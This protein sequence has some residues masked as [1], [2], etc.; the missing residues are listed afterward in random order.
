M[1][2]SLFGAL[3][4]VLSTSLFS[5]SNKVNHLK[6][7]VLYMP[8][9]TLTNAI[10]I[11]ENLEPRF[12]RLR[13]IVLISDYYRDNILD[14]YSYQFEVVFINQDSMQITEGND[15]NCIEIYFSASLPF[16]YYLNEKLKI[17]IRRQYE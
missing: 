12:N 5:I 8:K 13:S 3:V 15:S 17:S 7:I 2:L 6:S 10:V 14:Q 1:K 9:T 16:N 4:L 11:D